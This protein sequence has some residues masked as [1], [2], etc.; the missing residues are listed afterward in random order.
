[1]PF[2]VQLLTYAVPARY[3]VSILK[4]IYLKGVGLEILWLDAALLVAFAL[5]LLFFAH[6]R[7]RKSLD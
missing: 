4:S 5:A 3:F 6:L 7:F 2:A 1:M